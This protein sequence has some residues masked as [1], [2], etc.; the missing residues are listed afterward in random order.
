MTEENTTVSSASQM[1]L[2]G[3]QKIKLTRLIDEGIRIM[4]EVETINGGLTDTVKAVAE[5]LSVK[6]GILK[7]AIRTAYKASLTQT[8]EDNEVLNHLLVSAGKTL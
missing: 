3:D 1:M 7:K 5:E 6:P 4:H 2:S 8:N